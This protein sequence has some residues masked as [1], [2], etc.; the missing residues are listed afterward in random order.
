MV[1]V[2]K[3][4]GSPP[5]QKRSSAR[6]GVTKPTRSRTRRGP[7]ERQYVAIDLHLKRSVIVRENAAGEELG[8]TQIDNDPLGSGGPRKFKASQ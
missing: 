4:A 2:R 8:V 1:P 7:V 6:L 3:K 5:A